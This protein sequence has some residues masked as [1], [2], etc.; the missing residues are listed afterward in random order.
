[1]ARSH[2][3]DGAATITGTFSRNFATGC[4]FR[5]AFRWLRDAFAYAGVGEA[6]SDVLLLLCTADEI[7]CN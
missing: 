3:Y 5:S 6:E 2:C 1:M 7:G 4:K